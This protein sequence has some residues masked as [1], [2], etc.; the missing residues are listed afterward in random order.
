MNF[1]PLSKPRLRLSTGL[2]HRL[3]HEPLASIETMKARLR[4]SLASGQDCLLPMTTKRLKRELP[5]II[6]T[7]VKVYSV[8]KDCSLVMTA[9][10]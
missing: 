3:D 7:T 2:D 8:V 10:K 1:L 6:E 5:A 4:L 9:T